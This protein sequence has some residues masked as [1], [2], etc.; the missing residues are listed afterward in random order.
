MGV[1]AVFSVRSAVLMGNEIPGA[2]RFCCHVY[3]PQLP[4]PA[5]APV[6]VPEF[7][8]P[9]SIDINCISRPVTTSGVG[10]PQS[11]HRKLYRPVGVLVVSQKGHLTVNGTSSI[12]RTAPSQLVP[13]A[14][15]A[16]QK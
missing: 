11:G 7:A 9:S 2:V 16:K 3:P 10:M 8:N 15:D 12:S 14:A 4:G 1:R 6:P 5:A 13:R